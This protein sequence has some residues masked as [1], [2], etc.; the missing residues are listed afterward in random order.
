M[1]STS[2]RLHTFVYAALLAVV[3]TCA[4]VH[5]TAWIGPHLDA[6]G[7]NTVT[8]TAAIA[9]CVLAPPAS[10]LMAV[11]SNRLIKVQERLAELASTDPLT[12]LMNRRSFA[13]QF[14][15]EAELYRRT[16]RPF[17]LLLLN[18]DHFKRLNHKYG[19]SAGDEAIRVLAQQLK[20]SSRLGTDTVARWGGEEFALILSDS[21]HQSAIR[22]A[23]RLRRQ[24]ETISIDFQGKKISLQASI[25][26]VVCRK[27]ETL[28][29]SIARA[30]KC[31]R[32]AKKRGR[33]RVIAYPEE[34]RR[35]K[36]DASNAA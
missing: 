21:G 7:V 2:S 18:L 14:E 4:T 33:N 8:I 19:H 6:Y 22:A 25:G 5:F 20:V 30:D 17:S 27:D 3:L 16:N 23:E 32:E 9:S 35:P 1:L 36:P 12:E 28:E 11:Y 29:Q 24:I 10:I 13:A 26:M 34:A 15:R 31:L